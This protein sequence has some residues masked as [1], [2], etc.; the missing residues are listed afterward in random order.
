M[1]SN[2]STLYDYISHI[3][4]NITIFKNLIGDNHFTT[5]EEKKSYL[6]SILNSLEELKLSL[7]FQ[8]NDFFQDLSSQDLSSQDLDPKELNSQNLTL[9]NTLEVTHV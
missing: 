4:N 5:T 2:T 6:R 3:T 9:K 1:Y 7:A 8:S